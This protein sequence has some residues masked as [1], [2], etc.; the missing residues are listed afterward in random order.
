MQDFP[1]ILL[2]FLFTLAPKPIPLPNRELPKYDGT[3]IYMC[4]YEIDLIICV[5]LYCYFDK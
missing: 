3:Q 4:P 2:L 1:F 5:C